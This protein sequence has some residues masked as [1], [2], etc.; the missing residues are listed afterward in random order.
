MVL[1]P[2]YADILILESL[3]GI[4][5]PPIQDPECFVPNRILGANS[6]GALV[7]IVFL[8]VP[9]QS[10]HLLVCSGSRDPGRPTKIVPASGVSFEA[11]GRFLE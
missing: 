1:S 2:V 3:F 10:I 11:P 6:N 8:T 5:T 9:L 7:S 4:D